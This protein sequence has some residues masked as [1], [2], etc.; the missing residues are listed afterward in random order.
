MNMIKLTGA[1]GDV[2]VNRNAIVAVAQTVGSTDLLS[3]IQ[4][5]GYSDGLFVR[6][7]PGEVVALMAKADSND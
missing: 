6:E 3:V 5:N 7:S 1:H 4:I 2:Y